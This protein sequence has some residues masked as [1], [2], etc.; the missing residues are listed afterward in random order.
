MPRSQ[1]LFP[2][3]PG[4]TPTLSVSACLVEVISDLHLRFTV[5]Y[6]A[7]PN[8]LAQMA[9]LSLSDNERCTIASDF[10]QQHDCCMPSRFEGKL[11]NIYPTPADITSPSCLQFI[12]AWATSQ[13]VITKIVEFAHRSMS[14]GTKAKGPARPADFRVACDNFVVNRVSVLH[15]ESVKRPGRCDRAFATT[16]RSRLLYNM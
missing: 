9:D 16:Q 1:L 11:R 7:F 2:H 8:R 5:E 10:L 12:D 13:I 14:A 3:Q 4:P 6:T 15:A